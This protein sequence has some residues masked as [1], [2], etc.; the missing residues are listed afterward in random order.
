[1]KPKEVEK[2]LEELDDTITKVATENFELSQRVD[3]I[4][5]ELKKK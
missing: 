2:K 4:E 1:M 5:E 3:K